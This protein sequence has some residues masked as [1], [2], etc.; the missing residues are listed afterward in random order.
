MKSFFQT[1]LHPQESRELLLLMLLTGAV[2][3]LSFF[4]AAH[5]VGQPL[6]ERHGFRQT[7]TALTVFWMLRDGW[8]FDYETPVAGY[9]WSIPFEF[10]LYQAA[11]ALLVKLTGWP[12]DPVGRVLSYVALL[13]C[14]YP[15]HLVVQRLGLPRRVFW[16]FCALLW[17]SPIYLFWGRS[18]MIETTALFF[19]F[20]LIPFALDFRETRV[21]LRSVLLCTIFGT[22]A[23][24]QKATTG[25]PVIMVA[26][27]AWLMYWF[28]QGGSRL[29]PLRNL[30]A[31]IFT[32][33]LPILLTLLWTHHTDVIKQTNALGTYL[34]S[35]ALRN[36]NFGYAWQRIT[37][38]LY[39]EVLWRRMLLSNIGGM[40]GV[41]LLLGSLLYPGERK[42][43]LLVLASLALFAIPIMLFTNLHI[44]HD[45]YQSGCALFIIAALAISVSI[46]LPQFIPITYAVTLITTLIVASNLYFFYTDYYQSVTKQFNPENTRALAIGSVVRAH[47]A[48]DDGMLVFGN[49]WSSDIAYYAERKSFTVANFFVDY[50][51]VWKN[52]GKYL[53]STP[54]SAIVVCPSPKGPDAERIAKEQGWDK[55]KAAGC[56]VLLRRPGVT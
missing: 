41:A 47:T 11:V 13:A 35:D 5:Y 55:V 31:G 2:F 43:R 9:P 40:L 34:T 49:D 4:V 18:F 27:L 3:L 56:V 54:L 46:W 39:G 28:L 8:L 19:T 52:P 51:G 7:Q 25:G 37:P 21:P 14:A 26:G 20:A 1:S 24:L 45:Y 16:V 23:C 33:G 10:P 15:A 6:L 38:Y 48:P 12:I 22:L 32:F 17:S 29:P 44:E 42:I 36:W 53:G 30:M 50:D